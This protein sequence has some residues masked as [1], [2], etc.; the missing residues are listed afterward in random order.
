MIILL[1]KIPKPKTCRS[2]KMI[3]MGDLV[4]FT[5]AACPAQVR[6]K[7]AHIVD[8]YPGG[9]IMTCVRGTVFSREEYE[10]VQ[11]EVLRA[12]K[13]SSETCT[14]RSAGGTNAV[15]A[16]VK[17]ETLTWHEKKDILNKCGQL[18][19]TRVDVYNGK[20]REWFVATLTIRSACIAE[21]AA[22]EQA[23]VN[24]L[25]SRCEHDVIKCLYT[26]LHAKLKDSEHVQT[27]AAGDTR[28]EVKDSEHVEKEAA[29]D[30]ALQSSTSISLPESL[31]RVPVVCATVVA[32]GKVGGDE[33]STCG[34]RRTHYR[35]I[36]RRDLSEKCLKIVDCDQC[37]SFW[38]VNGGC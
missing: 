32:S 28:S 6:G 26:R 5:D 19:I 16:A 25:F 35:L 13:C 15:K 37:G 9:T 34:S 23:V 21:T 1:K 8:I 36:Q 18:I 24:D 22:T 20:Q 31:P 2:S 7:T 30:T 27:E 3:F 17:E 11:D 10:R 38:T 4:R 33:C 29:R 12:S 14:K